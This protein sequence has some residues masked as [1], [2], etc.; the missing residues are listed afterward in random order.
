MRVAATSPRAVAQHSLVLHCCIFIAVDFVYDY[1]SAHL[2][3]TVFIRLFGFFAFFFELRRPV[4]SSGSS[5]HAL[6]HPGSSLRFVQHH[7]VASVA[8]LFYR[9][10]SNRGL[11]RHLLAILRL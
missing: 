11:H 8:I 2:V 7:L 9:F 1:I 5:G 10:V 4:A 6:D 3:C